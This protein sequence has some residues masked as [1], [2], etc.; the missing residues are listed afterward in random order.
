MI[1]AERKKIDLQAIMQRQGIKC[2]QCHCRHFWKV[3]ESKPRG[4]GIR[5]V[6]TCRNCGH[7]LVTWERAEG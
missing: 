2:P 1:M 6:R 4:G 7:E 5:R 3:D